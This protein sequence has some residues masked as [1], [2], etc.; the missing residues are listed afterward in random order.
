ME[1]TPVSQPHHQRW[2]HYQQDGYY[3]YG[4]NIGCHWRAQSYGKPYNQED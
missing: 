2:Q 1:L 3:A 4:N